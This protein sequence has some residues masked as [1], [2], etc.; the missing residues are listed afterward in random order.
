MTGSTRRFRLLALL[1]VLCLATVRAIPL[2]ADGQA[3]P[4]PGICRDSD[5]F[6]VWVTRNPIARYNVEPLH[7][8]WY[9]SWMP[10]LAPSEPADMW[11]AQLVRVSDDGPFPDSACSACP[12]WEEVAAIAERNTGTLW[13]IGNEPDRQ[14]Y[15]P[16][17]NYARIYRDLY[18]FLKEHDPSCLVGIGGVVQPTPIRLQYL[19]MI[20]GAYQ[21]EYGEPMPIDVWNTHNYV[22]DEGVDGSGCG[23]PPGTDP[24]LARDYEIQDHDDLAQW[25]SHVV[26]LRTW[27]RDRGYQ[28][29]PLI[30]SEFGILMGETYGYYY[31]RV[32]AFMVATFDWMLIATDPDIGN[33]ADGYRLV[34]AWNWYSLD[35]KDFEGW[36]T[37]WS[38]LFDPD[39]LEITN[40]GLDFGAYTGPLMDP[41]DAAIDLAPISIG[42]DLPVIGDTGHLTVTV[43]AQIRNG[44]NSLAEN[45]VVQFERDGV[46]A[47]EDAIGRLDGGEAQPASV[48]WTH[49]DPGLY[50][51]A[52]R[53]IPSELTVECDPY[54]NTLTRSLLV[55]GADHRSYLPLI[56][57]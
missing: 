6:G 55:V 30:V 29:R 23:I 17:G 16:A 21:G 37:T 15:V 41:F 31:Q 3:P 1:P 24:S 42:H 5:R 19:D 43:T 35:H 57:R 28:D 26:D 25:L 53:V 20:L 44:G 50:E 4:L 38:H 2:A 47:G 13:L 22:L 56:H 48:V 10:Q 49:L 9:N 33:P 32:K 27:M 51:V 34:Q 12:T 45:V 46:P 11:F 54:N 7:A 52:V 36:Q 40:L 8:G 18:L 39:T 14:D